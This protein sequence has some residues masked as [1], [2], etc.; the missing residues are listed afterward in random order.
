MADKWENAETPYTGQL[1]YPMKFHVQASHFRDWN[2]DTS[3]G[4]NIALV[5]H[6]AVKTL[7]LESISP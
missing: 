1:S 4:G 2:T 6:Q 7:R 3:L 5:Y